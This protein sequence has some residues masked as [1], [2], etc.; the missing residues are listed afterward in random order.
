[1]GPTDFLYINFIQA[2]SPEPVE[3]FQPNVTH[4]L[5]TGHR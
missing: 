2:I 5:S 1:M 4:A 3:E